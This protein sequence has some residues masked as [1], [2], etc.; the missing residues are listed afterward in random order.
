MR[1]RRP[2][3]LLLWGVGLLALAAWAVPLVWMVA[4][5]LTPAAD[6]I[7]GPS[8]PPPAPTGEHYGRAFDRPIVR[9]FANSLL[10]AAVGTG[11]GLLSGAL[12]GYAFARFHFPGRSLLFGLALLTVMVPTE[13]TVVPLMLG[14]LRL[15]IADS[16]AALI[17]PALANVIGVYL[18]RQF[19]LGLPREIEEAA[20]LDG[21]GSWRLFWEVALPLARPA[22]VAAAVLIFTANW[23]TLL[24]PLLITFREE[25]QTLLVGVAS[26]APSVGGQTQLLSYGPAMAAATILTLPSLLLF[27]VFSE[28]V[29]DGATA[30]QGG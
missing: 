3:D 1:P 29:I 27:L 13:M 20:R 30:G 7:A 25:M 4:S 18:F 8:W 26:F 15:G 14:F 21:A 24:W 17:L 16:Y 10:V 28:R 22:A 9:W 6:L 19:F 2:V 5:S 11:Y 23:N 12:A